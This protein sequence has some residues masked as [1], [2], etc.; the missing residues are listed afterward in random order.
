MTAL[1]HPT[2]VDSRIDLGRPDD[3]PTADC[4][5]ERESE[6]CRQ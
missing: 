6:S 2:E 5:A 4:Q 3:R 1:E